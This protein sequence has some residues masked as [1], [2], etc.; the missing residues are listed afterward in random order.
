MKIIVCVDDN[1]GMLF[2]KRRQ[3]RDVKVLDDIFCMTDKLWIHP[4]SEKLYEKYKEK[5]KVDDSFLEE[6]GFGEFCFVENISLK[7]YE[8]KIEQ[9]IVYKWNRKYPADFKL[10]LDLSQWHLQEAL[11]FQGNSHDLITR[12][13]YVKGATV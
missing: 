9:L 6:A 13:I 12:E 4:F 2:N 11:E 10:D 1:M 3:S 7:P 8:D 5:T